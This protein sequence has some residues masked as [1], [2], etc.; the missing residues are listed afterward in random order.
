MTLA[1]VVSVPALMAKL[2]PLTA[3]VLLEI[4]PELLVTVRFP[5]LVTPAA[6]PDMVPELLVNIDVAHAREDTPGDHGRVAAVDGPAVDRSHHGSRVG[7]GDRAERVDG[8]PG[9]LNFSGV[10]HGNAAPRPAIGDPLAR[11]RR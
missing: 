2:L 11:A 6:L 4:V 8:I 7:E 9:G 1:S 10:G 3:R 5:P